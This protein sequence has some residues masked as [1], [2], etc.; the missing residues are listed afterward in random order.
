M[1]RVPIVVRTFK[2]AIARR[3]R[4]AGGD[5]FAWQRNYCER[6]IR[7]ERELRTIRHYI[8][9]NPARWT[10]DEEFSR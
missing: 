1:R 5:G 8:R 9:R 2:A 6:I 4:L 3:I 7:D 10:D